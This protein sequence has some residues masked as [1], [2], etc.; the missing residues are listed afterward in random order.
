MCIQ[1]INEVVFVNIQI[2]RY[3]KNLN[4]KQKVLQVYVV[5]VT[6]SFVSEGFELVTNYQHSS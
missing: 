2:V 5:H 3:A 6:P 1:L 4:S